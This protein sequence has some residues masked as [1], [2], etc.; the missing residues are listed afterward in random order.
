MVRMRTEHHCQICGTA[1]IGQST[2]RYCSA[3]C[4]GRAW[5]TGGGSGEAAHPALDALASTTADPRRGADSDPAAQPAVGRVEAAVHAELLD[6]DR[7][8]FVPGAVALALA[9]RID[10]SL[11]DTG[12]AVAS[13]A[14]QL[15]VTMRSALNGTT[16]AVDDLQRIRDRARAR[17]D[18]AT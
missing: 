7:L 6:A 14:R 10:D 8:R 11:R 1:F 18:A 5:R 9:R 17:R 16:V 2:A 12:S 3:T 13:L 4:R 15:D